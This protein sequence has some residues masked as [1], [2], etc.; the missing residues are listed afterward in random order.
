MTLFD[1]V[2]NEE[3]LGINF[4]TFGFDSV[5]FFENASSSVALTGA[6]ILVLFLV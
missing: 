3:V 2:H 6:T 4:V 1:L 5:H